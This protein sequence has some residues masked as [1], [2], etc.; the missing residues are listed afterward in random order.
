MRIARVYGD[1]FVGDIDH[2]SRWFS[3]V[4]S[5][6]KLKSEGF[7]KVRD[8]I[9][10]D[11]ST[12]RIA[13]I[14]SPYV[15]GDFVIT[16]QLEALTTDE[17]EAQKTSAL[18]NIRMTRNDLLKDTD[19]AAIKASETGSAMATAMVTYR[20]ALRDVPAS[21]GNADPREWND[22]PVLDE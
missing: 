11:P 16:V 21:I 18:E 12:Q 4:P 19:W 5:E 6:E 15:D 14:T 13:T 1:N 7:L 20:Q 8:Y 10:H 9:P 22:W 2:W 17:I 3:G